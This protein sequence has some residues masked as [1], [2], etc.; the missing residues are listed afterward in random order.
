MQLRVGGISLY[1]RAEIVFIKPAIPAARNRCPILD[2]TLP[3]A[4]NPV[5]EVY[6]PNTSVAALISIGSPKSVP[7]P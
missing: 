3:T 5:L 7:V 4:Q 1:R 6:F 2:F